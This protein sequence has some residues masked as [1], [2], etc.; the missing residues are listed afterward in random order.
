M[1]VIEIQ[2]VSKSYP[3]R[4]GRRALTGRG[5][6]PDFLKGRVDRRA[7]VLEDLSL[8]VEAGETLGIIGRNGS[9]KS[10]LL[11]MIAGVTLPSSGRVLV[12]GHVASL[13]EL[14]AGF[15]PMLTG[16][17]NIYLN[18]GWLGMRAVSVDAV[19]SQV[20]D[21][22]G[23]GEAIDQPVDTYSSGMYV[24]LGF[25]VAVHSNPDVFLV[26]EVLAV[27]DEE[28]QRKCRRKIGELKEQGKTIVFV[29][30]DLGAVHA[31]CDRVIL[32]QQGRLLD[33]GSAQATIDF[34][35]RQVGGESGMH[36]MRRG[37]TEAIFSHGRLSLF[38]G[39]REFTAPQGISCSLSS[40]GS[41]HSSPD[42][43]WTCE[44][45]S[46]EA[47]VAV[48]RFSRVPAALHWKTELTDAG[49][50][51]TLAL[52]LDRACVLEEAGALLPFRLAY[53]H[54]HYGDLSGVFPVLTP[55]QVQLSI[56]V[57]PTPGV[58]EAAVTTETEA[59]PPIE[60]EVLEAHPY[61]MLQLQN[62]EYM[63]G[64]RYVHA[65]LR[66]PQSEQPLPPGRHALA[67]I[68][69]RPAEDAA[70][71]ARRVQARR[72]HRTLRSGDRTALLEAGAVQVFAGGQPVSANL[73][74][75]TQ[76]RS[77]DL[78]LMSHALHW[79]PVMRQ[80][81]ALHAEGSSV[82][83]P[84]TQLWRL[85]P[86]PGG[87]SF[88]LSLELD[89]A[90]D[91]QEY[92]VSMTLDYRYACWRTGQESGDF[93]AISPESQVWVH[94]NSH[95]GEG[96]FIEASGPELPTVRL[97]AAAPE[98]FRA[99]AVNPAHVQQA[100]VIQLLRTPGP[101]GVFHLEPGKHVLFSGACLIEPGA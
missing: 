55:E 88:E 11:K 30:H 12:H 16:R 48:G 99:T 52:E 19:L 17:E 32:L 58:R 53:T 76:L 50:R 22:A 79:R 77:G 39:Q 7:P 94:L 93:P 74:W 45:R 84:G 85:S 38:Q 69:L 68:L 73:H 40:L 86:C 4:R 59:L 89:G 70:A 92:N 82:R 6:V 61:L 41:H 20:L 65:G 72:E 31:L 15:H 27:G 60:L 33:R 21:F 101:S 66:V 78:W 26:D 23:I 91:L 100:R 29:S 49:V 87:F 62:S 54:W 96:N 8:T 5:G 47:C 57:P 95:Y 97:V 56:V 35:L 46:E 2:H 81:G 25:A 83:L 28:F 67:T 9:G 71:V 24:R 34:Y 51:L 75:H 14:G 80:D 98:G 42:A 43:E 63:S 3:P 37:E 18:A 44:R 13:L 64:A 90:F 36:L 1:P 10:T